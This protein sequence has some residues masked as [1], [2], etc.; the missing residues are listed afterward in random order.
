M[1]DIQFISH[2]ND[3]IGYVDGI[4][5]ALQGGCKWIQLRMKGATDDE[6][7]QAAREVLP[8]CRRAGATFV[9]D[10]RVHL[11]GQSGADGVHLGKNDM[12]V[13][14]AREILG[15]DKIIGGTANTF[16]DIWRIVSSGADYIGCGPFR[17][18]TT[19]EKLAPTLGLDGYRQLVREMRANQIHQP[20]IAIGGITMDDIDSLK[21]IGVDGI[22]VS[23]AILHTEHPAEAMKRFVDACK[24]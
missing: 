1:K 8:D 6:V 11:V 21:M 14:Q 7:L 19:K 20:L 3:H 16:K 18:T 5:Q 17:Y 24:E 9:L 2:Q 12:D 13:R 15:P 22:A 10:D 23:G 4:R